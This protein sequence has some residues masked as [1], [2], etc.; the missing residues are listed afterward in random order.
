MAEPDSLFGL[1]EVKYVPIQY[2]V[3]H[4][5]QMGH[6][7][8]ILLSYPITNPC[9]SAMSRDWILESVFDLISSNET[10]SDKTMNS[11]QVKIG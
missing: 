11:R 7:Q 5:M 6:T 8:V 1:C 2:D 10:L 4:Y 3:S 9:A